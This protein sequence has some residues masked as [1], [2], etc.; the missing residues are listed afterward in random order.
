MTTIG[1]KTSVATSLKVTSANK[2]SGGDIKRIV[3]QKTGGEIKKTGGGSKPKTV[4]RKKKTDVVDRYKE[5]TDSLGDNTKALENAS[6]AS[7][8]LYGKAV[9]ADSYT[10]QI[11]NA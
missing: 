2:S 1:E 11:K 4:D 3:N 5:V 8:G 9:D 7:E 6:K 10:S